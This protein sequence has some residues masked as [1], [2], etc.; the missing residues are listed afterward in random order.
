[1]TALMLLFMTF[2]PR[3]LFL[4]LKQVPHN[5]NGICRAQYSSRVS[6]GAALA[7][8]VQTV[9]MYVQQ[10]PVQNVDKTSWREKT[11]RVLSRNG[12]ALEVEARLQTNIA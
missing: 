11:K 9:Q 6:V 7:E 5:G 1:M 4:I 2:L 10:Q 8:P 3:D 12:P